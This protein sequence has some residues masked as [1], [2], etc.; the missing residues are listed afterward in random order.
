M[1]GRRDQAL[2]LG[3]GPGSRDGQVAVLSSLVLHME[4]QQKLPR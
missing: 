3:L 1:H 4:I 2:P